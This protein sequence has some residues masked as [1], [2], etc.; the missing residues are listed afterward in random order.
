MTF[1]VRDL[2]IWPILVLAFGL[3][4][5]GL[6]AL[7]LTGDEAWS[8]YLALKDLP[9]L[10]VAT[11]MDSHP[12][13]YYYLLHSWLSVVGVGELTSRFLSTFTGLLTVAVTYRL[14]RRLLGDGAGN[15]A[16]L[17]AAI[18][19]FLVYFDRMPRNYSLPTFLATVS[20][21]LV[22]RLLARPSRL[23]VC[24]YAVTMLGM[25]YTHYYGLFVFVIGFLA[26]AFGWRHS[27]K[28]LAGWTAV[29]AAILLLF[30]P[31]VIYAIGPSLSSTTSDYQNIALAAPPNIMVFLERFWV[32]LNVGNMWKADES[33]ILAMLLSLVWA[34][35]LFT[36]LRD[37][38]RF[39]RSAEARIM[40]VPAVLVILPLL[41]NIVVFVLSPYVPFTRQLLLAAPAYLLLLAWVLGVI[42]RTSRLVSRLSTAL[43]VAVLVY[44]LAGTFYVENGKADLDAMEV[45]DKIDLMGKPQDAVLFQA[46]WQAGYFLGHSNRPTNNARALQEVPVEELPKLLEKHPRLWLSMFDS[47]KRLALHPQEEWLDRNAY[48][49]SESWRGRLRLSL[50]GVKP[51]PPL[52]SL[53]VNLGDVVSLEAAGV[54]PSSA[55]PGDVLKL[56]LRWRALK[57]PQRKYVAFVHLVNG[58]QRG[59]TSRDGEPVDGLRP[60]E[61]WRAGDLID[62]RRGLLIGAG[63]PP[64]EYYLAVGMYPREDWRQ[65]LPVA[66][67]KDGTLLLGPVEVL[68]QPSY[69]STVRP[70]ATS[71][72][73]GVELLKYRTEPAWEHQGVRNVDG[74]VDVWLRSVPKPG[75][76]ISVTLDWRATKAMARAYKVLLEITDSSGQAWGQSPEALLGDS[77]PTFRWIQGEVVAQS[78]Q[79]QIRPD[80][81]P[82]EYSFRASLLAQ[83]GGALAAPIVFG[84]LRLVSD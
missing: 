67:S 65:R 31:W 68:P 54:A 70:V 64:G 4:I 66:G 22:I 63:T 53:G 35:G 23:L 57:D 77:C 76:R 14:G 48:K 60:T 11:A 84:S 58:N 41:A 32:A 72:E 24:A 16:A 69:S 1:K 30:L 25:I 59:C 26:V 55:Y 52:Q 79:I 56:L 39:R 34:V 37:W 47:P 15:V 50:Y 81:P 5:I 74:P 78:S 33:R 38:K 49:A 27:G 83:D 20:I 51:D 9:D 2:W 18:S 61:T 29:Q 80:A 12:P 46:L 10:T 21:Y 19:P 42:W 28:R 13:L 75:A 7:Q 8:V 6:N 45:A 71:P 17:L 40:L 43:V 82:G 73:V 3:R 44:A 36:V 62:D